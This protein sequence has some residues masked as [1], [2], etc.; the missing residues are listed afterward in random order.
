MVRGMKRREGQDWRDRTGGTGREGQDGRGDVRM[1]ERKERAQT[2]HSLAARR[3]VPALFIGLV[4][5]P[6]DAASHYYFLCPYLYFLF[7]S[8]SV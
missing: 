6:P 8:V 5:L 2:G 1:G 7:S 4:R 3:Y